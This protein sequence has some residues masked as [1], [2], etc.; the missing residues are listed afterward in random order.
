[1]IDNSTFDYIF[2][3]V[4]IISLHYLTPLCV[5]YTA[6]LIFINGF[7]ATRYP[8]PL[9]IETLAVLEAL[10]F[11]LI[12]L[13]YRTFLQR[14][15]IHPTALSREQR[16]VLFERC[17][18]NIPDIDAYLQKWFLNAPLEEIKRDNFKDFLLWAFFNRP[19]PPGPDDEELEEYVVAT[20]KLAG[21]KFAPG[22]GK[23][24]CLRLTLD[25]VDMLHR[26]LLWYFCV[27]FVDFLTSVNLFRHGFKFHRTSLSQSLAIFPPRPQT[28][29]TSQRSAA[30]HLPYWHRP[31]TSKTKLPILFIHG[32]GIGLYPYVNFLSDL[33]ST[34]GLE[35]SDPDDQ[36]GIIAVELLPISFR[37]THAALSKDARCAEISMI[38][39]SHGWDKVVLVTHSYGSVVA[40]HL[41]SS[42]LTRA[43]I[44][45]LVLIDP[46]TILLHLPDVAYN[47][48]RRKPQKASEH[49][50]YYFASMDMGVAHTLSRHFFWSENV[51]WADD[52]RGRDVTV[53]LA[54]R[55]LIVNTA[56]VSRYL[57]G[58]VDR[59]RGESGRGPKGALASPSEEN[60]LVDVAAGDVDEVG[61]VKSGGLEGS[62]A[63]P[64]AAAA[65]SDV[66]A[67]VA[68]APAPAS[69][70]D[71]D[72]VPASTV[73]WKA[74]PWKPHGLS[75][76]YFETLDH[77]QVFDKA[78]TRRPLAQACRVY[79]AG[80]AGSGDE[81]EVEDYTD[82][83]DQR[84]MRLTGQKTETA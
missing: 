24:T 82:V 15:A 39:A 57:A 74:P 5:L 59:Q 8:I 1:M 14:D 17:N 13:P 47:F 58:E 80:G 66:S 40:T 79:S 75:L 31:H 43:H 10:F 37:L 68:T 19:G 48:T 42:P 72:T 7:G 78:S 4:C 67:V 35:S 27:G 63:E 3:R 23:A 55:D 34:H 6:V 38:L 49:Q 46:V 65:E 62:G 83:E 20:E 71:E 81:R 28:L 44:G 12:Y 45:P 69:A 30:P 73:P 53:S 56:A 18:A 84:G 54:G 2:I 26:S 77:A 11:L 64:D 60:L 9:I 76:L 51:I 41:L 22:R 25:Q 36:V 21:R 29:F 61:D 32:I 52:L 50:L 70:T 33:N 16:K